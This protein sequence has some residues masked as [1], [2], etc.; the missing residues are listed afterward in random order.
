M[1]ESS[2]QLSLLSWDRFQPQVD[3][4]EAAFAT[5]SRINLKKRENVILFPGLS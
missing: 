3:R 2:E 4:S 1:G 5:I